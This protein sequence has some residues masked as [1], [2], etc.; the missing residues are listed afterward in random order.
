M[1]YKL[2]LVSLLAFVLFSSGA[3]AKDKGP[4]E[5]PLH[6]TVIAMHTDSQVRGTPVYTDPYGKTHGGGVHTRHAS[7]YTIRTD[8]MDYDVEP[9]RGD[10]AVGDRV[11][12]RIEKHRVFVQTGD[13]E[14]KCWLMGE[15]TREA[16]PSSQR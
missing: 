11:A 2:I 4:K 9:R 3:S 6:G 13:K 5:Y 14:R 16:E 7:V 15:Q 1:R 8:R 12:F 10:L